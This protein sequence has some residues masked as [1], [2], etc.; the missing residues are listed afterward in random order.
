MRR[1][2]RSAPRRRIRG[3]LAVVNTADVWMSFSPMLV[4]SSLRLQ[5]TAEGGNDADSQIRDQ[6]ERIITMLNVV[7]NSQI[8]SYSKLS[9]E[10]SLL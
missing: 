7:A 6:T 4:M 1:P 3:D 2:S 10:A 9:Q 5:G 8:S